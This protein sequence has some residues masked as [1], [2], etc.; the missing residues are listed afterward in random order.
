MSIAWASAPSPVEIYFFSA[1]L[2]ACLTSSTAPFA[3]SLALSILPSRSSFFVASEHACGLL[4]PAFGLVDDFAHWCLQFQSRGRLAKTERFASPPRPPNGWSDG[5]DR[6]HR[7]PTRWQFTLELS[8][9]ETRR[10]LRIVHAK[11]PCSSRRRVSVRR[12]CGSGRSRRSARLSDSKPSKR[13]HFRQIRDEREGHCRGQRSA[14][15]KDGKRRHG[16]SEYRKR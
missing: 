2:T 4:D 6:E 10:A 13:G 16:D 14:D 12:P 1:S 5:C 3:L 15:E 7:C 11:R 9:C 8:F